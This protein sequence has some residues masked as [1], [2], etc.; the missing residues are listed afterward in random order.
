MH[1]YGPSIC[2]SQGAVP[3]KGTEGEASACHQLWTTA[4]CV[5][6]PSV[7]P[8]LSALP[9]APPRS[10]AQK[11]PAS[12]RRPEREHFVTSALVPLHLPSDS[13][14]DCSPISLWYLRLPGTGRRSL[15]W[16]VPELNHTDK[17]PRHPSSSSTEHYPPGPPDGSPDPNS[18]AESAAFCWT[19]CLN[20]S[21]KNLVRTCC[22][23]VS[24][25]HHRLPVCFYGFGVE[26]HHFSQKRRERTSGARGAISLV[27][28]IKK[29][30]ELGDGWLLGTAATGHGPNRQNKHGQGAGGW[31]SDE[32]PRAHVRIRTG[33]L[34]A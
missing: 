17:A 28:D 30:H 2:C 19:P 25:S 33:T 15:G 13:G 12:A 8:S 32:A 3:A 5:P 20:G 11:V 9:A 18:C 4:C 21:R 29:W 1:R 7:T 24:T 10:P 27:T 14:P 22:V 23:H 16:S 34:P 6:S 26:S 31:G